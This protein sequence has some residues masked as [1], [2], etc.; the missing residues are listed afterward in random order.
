MYDSARDEVRPLNANELFSRLP[1]SQR[2][3]RVYARSGEHA[4]DLARALDTLIE[5]TV[6]DATNM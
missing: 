2:I 1:T 3:C 6:D 4:A 5:G